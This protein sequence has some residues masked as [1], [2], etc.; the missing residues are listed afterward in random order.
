MRGGSGA[1]WRDAV[2]QAGQRAADAGRQAAVDVAG[3][4]ADL[5][6]DAFHGPQGVGDVFGGLQGQVLAQQLA[7]LTRG[8]EQ[9]GRA[10]RVAGPAAHGQPERRPPAI[11]TQPSAPMEQSLGQGRYRAAG[12]DGGE[13]PPGLHADRA[14]RIRR[15]IRCRA[16]STPGSPRNMA[17]RTPSDCRIPAR[18]PGDSG[19]ALQP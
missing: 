17:S 14:V 8:R 12:H 9:L 13:E 6:H 19:G 11:K 2:L 15:M 7:P 5:H 3:H 4:L 18:R 10:G 16:S 1:H